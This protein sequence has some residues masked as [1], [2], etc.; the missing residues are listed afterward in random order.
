MMASNT[1]FTDKVAIQDTGVELNCTMY[2]NLK[3]FTPIVVELFADRIVGFY[4][5]DT[6]KFIMKI[7]PEEKA[8]F[9]VPGENFKKGGAA[10]YVMQS[11]KLFTV[12][13]DASL[14]G[15]PMRISTI[16][17]YDDDT[18]E[19][20]GTFGV[21]MILDNIDQMQKI[22][23][24]FLDGFNEISSA[25]QQTA[26]G[27]TQINQSELQLSTEI[28][29]IRTSAQEILDILDS[30]KMIADQ[31]KMLGLNAAIEAARAGDTGRGF[32]VVA[33]EIRKLSASSKETAEEIRILTKKINEK[34][35]SATNSSQIAVH[36]SE[37]Q[38]AASQ[39]ITASIE[40][41]TAMAHKLND[42][43]NKM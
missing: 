1:Q 27:A 30:I 14:Y 13:V 10:D 12:E 11:G 3:S 4:A 35:D 31:T 34:I 19:A 6:E 36:A 38:A 22:S 9:A 39:E 17:L 20:I 15:A 33:E 16:P 43:A 5:T 28:E 7:D 37:E 41:L 18:G 29:E 8:P 24:S 32:G 26:A 2:K 21:V 40:E 25:T 42:I 23:Q